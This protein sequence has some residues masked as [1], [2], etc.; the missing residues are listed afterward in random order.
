[1]ALEQWE[2]VKEQ[3]DFVVHL[4][5]KQRGEVLADLQR[6]N[7]GLYAKVV[8]LVAND[9]EAGNFLAE[10]LVVEEGPRFADGEIVAGRYRIERFIGRG[11]MGEVYEAYDNELGERLALKTIIPDAA[12]DE[13]YVARLLRECKLARKIANR[14]VC[15]VHD[16]GHH[17][18]PW[19]RICF[20]TMELLDGET[21]ATRLH[22]CGRMSR[23]EAFPLIE[24]MA[25]ALRAAHE[26]NIIHRDFKPGNIILVGD[27][28]RIRVVVTDFGLARSSDATKTLYTRP[29]GGAPPGTIGYIA[30]EL[31]RPGAVATIASDIYSFGVVIREMLAGHQRGTGDSHP[32]LDARSQNA[33]R[34]CLE[35]DPER[36][37]KSAPD[38]VDAFRPQTRQ[39]RLLVWTRRHP[40]VAI[41]GVV[42]FAALLL[43]PMLTQR[44]TEPTELSL[45]TND[46]GLSYYPAVSHDGKLL[47]YA[48]DRDSKTNLD[49]YLRQVDGDESQ[50]LTQ[51]ESD[52]Y[53]PSFSPDATRIVFRSDRNGGGVYQV[54]TLGGKAQLLAQG[55]L[56]PSFSPDGQWIAYW[57]GLPGAGFL[58]GS[59][60]VYVKP[61]NGGPA[62]LVETNLVAT[63]WPIW[64]PDSKHLLVMGKPDT[65]VESS[66]SVDWFVIPLQ[67]GPPVKVSA[68]PQFR[69]QKL[70]PPLGNDWITPIAWL[71]GSSRVLFSASQGDTTNL[72]EV[73]VSAAGKVSGPATRQT[74]TTLVDL[75]AAIDERN[76]GS[77]RMFFSSLVGR[78]NV[79]SIPID[80]SSGR[81][82][83]PISDLTPGISYA[84]APS[85]SADGTEMA[86]IAAQSK[87][88]SVKTRDLATGQG[89]TLTTK[90]SRT[91][92]GA[93]WLRPRIS[94]DGSAV[95][96]VDNTDQMYLVN[97]LTGTSE[98]ICDRCGP[99]TDISSDGQKVLFQPL[100]PPEDVMMIDV[101]THRRSSLVHSDRQD[102]ILFVGRFSP[103]GQWVAFTASL[104][105]SPH[106]KLFISPI[107]DGHGV[108]EPDWI[109]VTDGSQVDVN[110]AW[111]PD[112]NVFYFLSERDGFR[113]IWAQRLKPATKRPDGPAFAVQHFHN[114]RESLKPIQEFDLIGLSVA[115]DKLVLSVNGLKGDIWMEERKLVPAGALSRWTSAIRPLIH[116]N[117]HHS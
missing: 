98:K 26:E 77:M 46:S 79:W 65:K 40:W 24:Q 87:L 7:P 114:A 33:I 113:C 25:Q 16:I 73:P 51:D 93:R 42:F 115:R 12:L 49:L 9:D 58:P 57:V 19:G 63:C 103:D 10:T 11:G 54:S 18:A 99:P 83:G 36:R 116:F 80:A 20:F 67:G 61:A 85:I 39:V 92:P 50:R 64:A 101:P 45:V 104:D 59:S 70:S 62:K 74:T 68:L 107:R 15:R 96:Y 88:W 75:Q 35:E 29:E 55:G 47:V 21:L 109:P 112:G 17:D 5:A 34:C 43:A 31:F 48:S 89:A 60:R 86:F 66:I 95:A 4:D 3:F 111:S 81:V 72:W 110:E 106:K 78:V 44:L 52:D 84:A 28:G 97:R 100:N 117:R 76:D 13:R 27:P 94:S 90:D 69:S 37:F 71:P 23:E 102:H 32:L 38:V 14:H 41:T 53:A 6:N 1:M 91:T 56:S 108:G 8:E 105:S 82:K 22:R 2:Q 30:P